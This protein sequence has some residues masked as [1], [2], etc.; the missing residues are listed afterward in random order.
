MRR[1]TQADAAQHR[2]LGQDTE[3][4]RAWGGFATAVVE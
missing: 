4:K 3:A 2:T 1:T